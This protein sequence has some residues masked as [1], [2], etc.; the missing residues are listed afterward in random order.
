MQRLEDPREALEPIEMMERAL[1]DAAHD[2]GAP[3]LLEA[4]DAI[5]V[6]QGTWKY[7]N[8]GALLAERVGAGKVETGIGTLSGHIVQVL[9]DWACAEIA[10]GRHDVVAIVGG[11]SEHSKRRLKRMGDWPSWDDN[12]AG[13]P[14]REFG[15]YENSFARSEVAVG[16]TKP[17]V[18]FAL[19][20]TALRKQL[21]STPAAH[22]RHISQLISSQVQAGNATQVSSHRALHALAH[23]RFRGRDGRRRPESL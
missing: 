16:I 21:G 8:P 6:P 18:C 10:A 7:G 4:L 22:R 2:A 19:A 15:S 17:S 3:R 5:L 9:L 11:E 14:D 1:R 20:E 12:I 23:D 13:T